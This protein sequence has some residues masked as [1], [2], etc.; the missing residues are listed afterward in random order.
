MQRMLKRFVKEESGQFAVMAAVMAVPLVLCVGIAIDTAYIHNKSTTLQTSLDSA[1]LAAVIPGNLDNEQ[2]AAYAKEVFEHNYQDPYP[3]DVKVVASADRVDIQGVVEKETLFMGLGGTNKVT[4]RLR[5]AAI[6]TVED[7]VCIM[8]LNESARGSL[9]F[10][11]NARINAP[12]C[13]IQVNSTDQN[14]LIAAGNY[15]PNAQRICVHGGVNGNVGANAQANCSALPDPYAHVQVPKFSGDHSECNYGP[16]DAM[17]PTIA[18]AAFQFLIFGLIQQSTVDL[19]YEVMDTTFAMGPNNDYRYPG[20]YCNGLHFY[21][22]KT[23]LMPGTYIMQD[24]PLSFGAG[25]EVTGE[26]VTFV[27]RGDKSYLYTYDDVSLDFTAPRTGKYAGL[28]F[29]Q[30]RHSSDDMTSIIKGNANIKL[31]GTSYFPTQD[32]FVG[33][34]G[35]MGATSPAMAFIADNITFTSDIDDIISDNEAEFQTFKFA[36]EEAANLLYDFGLSPY[37]ANY[38]SASGSGHGGSL[39]H[40]FTTNIQTHL[41]S[42]RETGI[43]FAKSDGGARLVSVDNSPL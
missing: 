30:D 10:E 14:A 24:G 22:A 2:R 15:K 25:A 13:S 34:L 27:F 3:V 43:P 32:L 37:Q 23:T 4:Q 6:K 28:I 20:V 31:V 19:V 16:L 8:T 29:M 33:G 1:A 12:S 26:G 7:V 35:E 5:A 40:D 9:T 36:M 18:Q 41:G 17:I 11:K 38:S 21:D 42:Q 39:Y